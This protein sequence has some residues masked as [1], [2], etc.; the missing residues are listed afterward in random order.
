MTDYKKGRDNKFW[1][2]FVEP[3]R[4]LKKI[5]QIKNILRWEWDIRNLLL[6]ELGINSALRISDLL[7]IQVNNLFDEQGNVKEYFDLKETKTSKPHRVTITPKVKNTLWEYQKAY[8]NIVKDNDNYIF[9]HRRTNKSWDKPIGRKMAWLMLSKWCKDVW[10]VGNYWG[11]T[12]RKTR[13]YQARMKGIS[14][15]V[16]QHKLNHSNM[17]VTKRYLWITNDEIEDACMKLD[18]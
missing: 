8:P 10:L 12:L 2:Q 15:E 11:H 9:F 3:I 6:F 18:L 5:A 14:L 13:G 1:M 4:D 17:A 16:I 7:T